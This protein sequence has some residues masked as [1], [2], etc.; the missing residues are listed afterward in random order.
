MSG[1]ALGGYLLDRISMMGT[2]IGGVL[3][4]LFSALMIGNGRKLAP[5]PAQSH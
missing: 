1:G 5:E 3:L 2:F 4:L